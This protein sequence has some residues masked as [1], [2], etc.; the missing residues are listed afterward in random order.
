MLKILFVFSLYR[1][2]YFIKK[3]ETIYIYQNFM[4]QIF[5]P[6]ELS[7]LH[8]FKMTLMTYLQNA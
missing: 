2:I 5:I 1:Y 7:G 4:Y 3:I 8:S 6:S